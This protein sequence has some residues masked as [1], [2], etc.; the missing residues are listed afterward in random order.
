MSPLL[1]TAKLTI[2]FGGLA[3]VN[4]VDFH[5][6]EGEVVGMIGPNGS[7]K[8]TFFNLLTGIYKP[9]AGEITYCEEN[10]VGLPAFKISQKGIART[11]QNNRLFLNLSVLDNVLIGMHSHQDSNWFDAIFRRRYVEGETRKGVQA[12]LELLGRFSQELVENCYKRVADLP[13]ADRRKVE[14]CRALASS[15]RL[16]L[17]DEPSAG[18]SPEETEEL[19]DDIR[20]VRERM[21]GIGI[22]IIEHDMMVIREVAERVV[23]LNY[24]RKIAEGTFQSISN[25]D[26]VLE[27]YLGREEKDAQA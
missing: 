26:V 21:Q 24:G 1:Q 4:E 27:A 19:M 20:K 18:M 8:T 11:F 15:P 17:L 23:V 13:Q 16:L 25:N 9:T 6:D 10:L 5:I 7:G 12:G 2:H 3:A 22:V 14:I